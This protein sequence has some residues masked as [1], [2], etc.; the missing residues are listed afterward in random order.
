MG[1]AS[2]ILKLMDSTDLYSG[3]NPEQKAA[4]RHLNGPALVIAG[5]GTGKTRVITSR[6]ARLVSEEKAKPDEILA[7]T[8]TDKAAREMEERVDVLLPLGVN[9]VNITTFNSFGDQL[10]K[11]YGVEI[12]LPT[13]LTVAN[14]A[15]QIFFLREHFD[16]LKLDYFAPWANPSSQLGTIL[17]FFSKLRDELID[18][19]TYQNY[20]DSLPQTADEADKLERAKHQEL[21]RVY[22]TYSRLKKEQGLIDYDDQIHLCI[23]L[24]TRRANILREVRKQY[25]FVLV[26]EFQDTNYAQ[27]QLLVLLAGD[28]GNLMAV[29]D[30]DQSIY[31]FRGA[32]VSN[33]LAFQE[34]FPKAT[35][36]VLTKNYRSTQ[37]IL[38]ASY[39]LITN[40]NPD[41]LEAKYGISKRL[42]T[43]KTGHEP[44]LVS[45]T[46]LHA[47]S[48][49]VAADIS[50][51]LSAGEL[52]QNIAVLIRKRR[53]AEE[54]TA[55][56]RNAGVP[57]R[58]VDMQE[59]HK[60]PEIE[61]L[62]Y[63]IQ[64]IADPTRSTELYHL[65]E[66][67]I[68]GIDI[69]FLT[70]C[71]AI[72]RRTNRTL[73]ATLREYDYEDHDLE[74]R[75][76]QTFELLDNLREA[77][78]K[79]TVREVTYQFLKRSGYLAN[80]EEQ[81]E[82][83]PQIQLIFEN[84]HRFFE[85]L[86]DYQDVA[87]DTS[88]VGFC[89]SFRDS[90]DLAGMMAFSEADSTSN[91]VQVLTIHQSKGLEFESVYIYDANQE[92]IPGRRKSEGIGVPD[93]LLKHETLPSGDW[94]IQE[95]R[96]LMYVAMT[97][98]KKRL[99]LSF[100]PQHGGKRP[101]KPSIFLSEIFGDIT[102]RIKA[103]DGLPALAKL[104]RNELPKP[105]AQLIDSRLL[106]DG[107]LHLTPHQIDDYMTCPYNFRYRHILQVPGEPSSAAMYGTLIHTA[108]NQYFAR[109]QS[110]N[111][112]EVK[113]LLDLVPRLWRS[114]GFESENDEKRR[115]LQ[116]EATIRSFYAREEASASQPSMVEK[117]FSVALAEF[118]VVIRGRI[119]AIYEK[120]DG[121]E[122]RDFKTS[123]TEDADKA[124]KKA[125]S[126]EQLAIY[127][128]A[129]QRMTGKAPSRLVLDFVDTGQEGVTEKKEKD[130]AKT[131]EK[132]G[133]VARGIR[134][135]E[136]PRGNCMFC[137]HRPLA[138]DREVTSA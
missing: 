58:Y 104:A 105:I 92:A 4:V 110:G 74:I 96:R 35:Q 108:I 68:F 101:R 102:S 12:G 48:E 16:E 11:Q 46:D 97:R 94:H 13:G 100:S 24:L 64:Y 130:L 95:E 138:I 44:I 118:E 53:Q 106:Q 17:D 122:I 73:D 85:A 23:E 43:D 25:K 93:E 31:K 52:P 22:A 78:R 99:V 80:L 72:A 27:N 126:S 98:A 15:Q 59:L 120:P 33:I 47:E 113:E 6:I 129:W 54:I 89:R 42:T 19:K 107:K 26:D 137:D 75:L 125:R 127:A 69:H 79:H 86:G 5:A 41:R 117:S 77:A 20:A 131:T 115:R 29:G 134:A 14:R 82:T 124:T 21:A 123:Q 112:V 81:A 10:L 111:K 121:V 7:L 50:A 55:A 1:A 132:I 60:R 65:L 103:S 70:L 90:K 109:R 9:T 45:E 76:N 36:I 8:F 37:Q 114:E 38:D 56:L 28:D 40:N 18:V 39:Q 51:Q 87:A 32:A 83:D 34:R 57:Y 116:A 119:D 91:E 30:D 88:I 67:E 61:V 136:F 63:F 135:G 3:L 84:Y 133:E 2:A 128:V 66:S 49:V 71:S 62:L